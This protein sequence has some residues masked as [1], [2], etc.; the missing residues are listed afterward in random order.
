MQRSWKLQKPELRSLLRP[1]RR[2]ISAAYREKASLLAAQHFIQSPYFQKYQHMAV[3]Q[4]LAEEIDTRPMVEALWEAGKSGYLPLVAEDKTNK[5]LKFGLYEKGMALKAN[6]F[7]VLE[8]EKPKVVVAASEL[9]LVIVPLLG[10]DEQGNRLGMGAGYYDWTF[11]GQKK[12]VMVGLGYEIQRVEELPREKFDVPLDG[13]IT[14][15][16]VRVF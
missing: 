7:G 8:P 13:V 4:A 2:L 14:E 16:K 3:Y 9:D 12:V 1:L 5:V 10:F 15:E 11:A 6:R